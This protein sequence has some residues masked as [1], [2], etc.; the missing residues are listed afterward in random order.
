MNEKRI[1]L[2]SRDD[3]D[4]E[5]L[6]IGNDENFEKTIYGD[7][8]QCAGA[9]VTAHGLGLFLAHR[10]RIHA[11]DMHHGDALMSSFNVIDRLI[12]SDNEA[13]DEVK[14]TLEKALSAHDADVH[15]NPLI[16]DCAT[17]VQPRQSG[18]FGIRVPLIVRRWI[19]LGWRINSR[20]NVP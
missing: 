4:K 18:G 7:L 9:M 19:R 8:L 17:D 15:E 20:N 5:L 2:P 11:A 10:V 3:M 13:A 12:S 1:T 14:G 16:P 6:R